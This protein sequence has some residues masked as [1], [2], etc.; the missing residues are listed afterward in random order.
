MSR[1]GETNKQRLRGSPFREWKFMQIKAE[2][3]LYAKEKE[4]DGM[5]INRKSCLN[6]YRMHIQ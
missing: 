6:I 2:R 3:I 4:E 1:G 5:Q